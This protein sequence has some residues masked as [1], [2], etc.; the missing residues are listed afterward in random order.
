[1]QALTYGNDGENDGDMEKSKEEDKDSHLLVY[2]Q[3]IMIYYIIAF[4]S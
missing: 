3:S 1:M 4:N 2:L